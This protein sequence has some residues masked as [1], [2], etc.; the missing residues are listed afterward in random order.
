MAITVKK[1]AAGNAPATGMMKT[2]APTRQAPPDA[3]SRIRA[4]SAQSYGENG[5]LNNA[6][7][8]NPGEFVESDLGRNMRQSVDDDGA[9]QAIIDGKGHGDNEASMVADLQRKIDTTPY[10]SAYGQQSRQAS[11]GSP[12]GTIPSKIGAVDQDFV[13]RRDAALKRTT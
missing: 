5:P 7:R 1:A 12:G 8:T 9:L 2:P 13:A 6:S 11:S 3:V 4:P 10:A